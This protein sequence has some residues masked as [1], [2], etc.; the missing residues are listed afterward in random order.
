MKN[1]TEKIA[2]LLEKLGL[3]PQDVVI[4]WVVSGT[5]DLKIVQDALLQKQKETVF[6]T[7]FSEIQPGMF[8]YDDGKI[9]QTYTEGQCCALVLDVHKDRNT[10]LM[11]CL[12]KA[13]LPFCSPECDIDT[14]YLKSGLNAT[15]FIRQMAVDVLGVSAD[16]AQ[17]CLEY[18]DKFVEPSQAFM[19][20]V[21][22]LKELEPNLSQI[23]SALREAGISEGGFWLSTTTKIGKDIE[24]AGAYIAMFM[25]DRIAVQKE[26]ASIP[27]AVYPVYEM[28]FSKLDLKK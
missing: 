12:R 13:L 6:V 4:D 28:K 20:T 2:S 21:D 27:Q 17:Y 18:C 8:L 5:I 19:L 16:A 15:H 3:T 23:G 1:K 25:P 22:E 14:A 9:S 26:Y 11:M 10:L 7:S 24:S